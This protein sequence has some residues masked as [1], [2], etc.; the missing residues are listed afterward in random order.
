MREIVFLA[1][2]LVTPPPPLFFLLGQEQGRMRLSVKDIFSPLFSMFCLC[3]YE[4]QVTERERWFTGEKDEKTELTIFLFLYFICSL[5][6]RACVPGT[7]TRTNGERKKKA[8][9]WRNREGKKD[10]EGN[11]QLTTARDSP[12]KTE[13]KYIFYQMAAKE[14]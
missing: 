6:F 5:S 9:V 7:V 4:P 2:I 1:N 10:T 14:S 13:Q 11:K 8:L 12:K 3:V